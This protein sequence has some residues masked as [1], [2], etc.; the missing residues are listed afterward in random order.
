VPQV[1]A[2]LYTLAAAW[3]YALRNYCSFEN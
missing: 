1:E 2:Y 3:F